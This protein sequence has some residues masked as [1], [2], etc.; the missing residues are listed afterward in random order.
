MHTLTEQNMAGA[1]PSTIT[2]PI[3]NEEHRAGGGI[4]T[5]I[6]IEGADSNGGLTYTAGVDGVRI[7]HLGG[8][9]QTLA[10]SVA[11]N[12]ITVQLGT[13]GGAVVTSTATAVKAAFDAVP[14]AVALASVLVTGTG[15][16]LAAMSPN[17]GGYVEISDGAAGSIYPAL[18]DLQGRTSYLAEHAAA[19]GA[20]IRFACENGADLSIVLSLAGPGILKTTGSTYTPAGLAN[21]TLYYVYAKVTS[22]AIAFEHGTTAP[23]AYLQY[24]T[25]STTTRY[26]GWFRTDGSAAIR[27]FNSVRGRYLLDDAV[28][29]GTGLTATT[30]TSVN[31]SGLVPPHVRQLT[32]FGVLTNGAG[33]AN[34]LEVKRGN[35]AGT[36]GIV[37]AAADGTYYGER[38]TGCTSGQAFYYKIGSPWSSSAALYVVGCQE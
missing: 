19:W 17:S 34:Y 13:D 10:V 1:Y 24:K 11:G 31:A 25:G 12:D 15:G 3:P 20:P 8:T 4:G 9:S 37:G 23:D 30:Y 26:V 2:V 27:N 18:R 5:P 22:S 6:T 33:G 32:I 16:G 29:V 36:L 7:R 35:A 38:E 21:S 28:A 14:A